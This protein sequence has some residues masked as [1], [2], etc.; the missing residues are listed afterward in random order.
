MKVLTILYQA[1]Q[2]LLR[3]SYDHKNEIERPLRC[4]SL[5]FEWSNNSTYS[6]PMLLGLGCWIWHIAIAEC[7]IRWSRI[8]TDT[9]QF[10]YPC[11]YR[12]DMKW[13]WI[14]DTSRILHTKTK[15]FNFNQASSIWFTRPCSNLFLEMNVHKLLFP[16]YPSGLC[17]KFD[18]SNVKYR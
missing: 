10:H 14:W 6:T 9:V 12:P 3:S 18:I 7:R 17:Y 5:Q 2:I 13:V 11:R 16:Y 4:L 1:W 8:R 15:H